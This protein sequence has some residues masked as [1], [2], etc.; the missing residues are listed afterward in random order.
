MYV[1]KLKEFLPNRDRNEKNE[2]R[3]AIK[4]A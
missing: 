4:D 3:S 1:I 2:K